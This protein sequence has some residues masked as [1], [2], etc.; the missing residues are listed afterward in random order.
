MSTDYVKVSNPSNYRGKYKGY[1]KAYCEPCQTTKMKV[2]AKIVKAVNHFHK[3]FILGI[4]QGSQN[5][6][7]TGSSFIINR[8]CPNSISYDFY[9]LFRKWLTTSLVIFAS[10]RGVM[11]PYPLTWEL[12]GS[13]WISNVLTFT[14]FAWNASTARATVCRC[15]R[16][17]SYR[18]VW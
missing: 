4:W 16:F 2:F 15:C 13:S 17:I 11:S 18:A 5:T 3:T 1:T 14:L 9:V 10:C 7:I 12:G 8:I 6:L